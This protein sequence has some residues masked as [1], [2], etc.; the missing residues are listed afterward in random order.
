MKKLKL[1]LLTI[2]AVLFIIP[3][4]FAQKNAD[5]IL[6]V[7]MNEDEDAHIE[8]SKRDNK[9]FGKLVWLKFPTDD[10]TGK[11]KLDK[12]NP[13]ENLQ[14]R[15]TWGLEMLTNFEFDGDDRWSK[16]KIYDPKKGKTYSCYMNFVE[17]KKIK[18]RGY[19]GVSILGKTTY[20]TRVE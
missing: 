1:I 13:D 20:W 6:G 15:P 18:I 8:I 19:I 7:W 12:H 4:S 16:G 3:T 17:D 14:S 9:Y 2:A 5:D 10:E 11:P